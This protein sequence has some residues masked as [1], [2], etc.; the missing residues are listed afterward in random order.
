MI[1]IA[2]HADVHTAHHRS[3]VAPE[4]QY[5]FSRSGY[6]ALVP[7]DMKPKAVVPPNYWVPVARMPP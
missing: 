5:P 1:S 6:Y 3:K 2:F 7:A 4:P